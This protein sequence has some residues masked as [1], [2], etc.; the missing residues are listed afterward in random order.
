MCSSMCEVSLMC[1]KYDLFA[2]KF[3]KEVWI[4]FEFAI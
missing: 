1:F 4:F 2:F 3:R